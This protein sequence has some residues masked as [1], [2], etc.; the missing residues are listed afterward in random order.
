MMKI[1]VCVT[2]KVD[3]IV[4][5][6]VFDTIINVRHFSMQLLFNFFSSFFAVIITTALEIHGLICIYSFKELCTE[7]LLSSITGTV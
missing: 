7:K 1:D 4:I 3:I 5:F 2:N 6:V